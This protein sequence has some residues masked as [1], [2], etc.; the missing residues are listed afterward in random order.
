MIFV[1]IIG[2]LCWSPQHHSDRETG[3]ATSHDVFR[4]VWWL[5]R[6]VP[7]K[8]LRNSDQGLDGAAG[9]QR[10]HHNPR[11][12]SYWTEQWTFLFSHL[13][14][15]TKEHTFDQGGVV[16]DLGCGSA[17]SRLVRG[18]LKSK[19]SS[20]EWSVKNL[21]KQDSVFQHCH[22]ERFPKLHCACRWLRR[23]V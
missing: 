7:R 22:G 4:Q 16:L 23:G 11:K 9:T 2:S 10:S 15:L 1:S 21:Q 6:E 19:I 13:D 12:G 5:C 17:S 8:D 14:N 18:N 20:W 3:T